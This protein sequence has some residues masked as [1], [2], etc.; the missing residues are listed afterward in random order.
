[1]TT[2]GA[3]LEAPDPG[4]F[5]PS[6]VAASLALVAVAMGWRGMDL[7]AQIYRVRAVPPQRPRA[8]G[9]PVVRR[10]LDP[11]LQRDLPARRGGA[12][13]AGHRG[14]HRGG[15][16]MGIRPAGG[17]PLRA[18]RPRRLDHVRGGDTGPGRDRPAA[19][20]PRRGAGTGRLLGGDAEALAAGL[21]AGSCRLTGE[22]TR[23]RLPRAGPHAVVGRGVVEGPRATPLHR[24]GHRGARRCRGAARSRA[25]GRC[26]SRG[27]ASPRSR[28]WSSAPC[29]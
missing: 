5:V 2:P 29:S 26:R 27:C 19:V 23:S 7:P 4:R 6:L 18:H 13:H 17:R 28:C 1:M 16:R 20:P 25:R 3:S 15:R 10:P 21:R 9:Q 11:E 12:R 8:V 22:P 14:A 24:G